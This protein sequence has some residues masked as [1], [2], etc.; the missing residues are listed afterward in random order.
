MKIHNPTE[1]CIVRNVVTL[2]HM[3]ALI[4]TEEEEARVFMISSSSKPLELCLSNKAFSNQYEVTHQ[5]YSFATE[6]P[7][8]KKNI[9]SLKVD[10]KYTISL[11]V[12]D[13]TEM[14]EED[15][16]YDNSETKI[17]SET[18]ADISNVRISYVWISYGNLIMPDENN[19][20]QIS[21]F[22]AAAEFAEALNSALNK[23]QTPKET[24]MKNT[25]I[26]KASSAVATAAQVNKNALNVVA[27]ISAGSTVLQIA[28]NRIE[29][30]VP[31]K[32]LE[33][34]KAYSATPIG[35]YAIANMIAMAQSQFLAGNAKAE[36]IARGAVMA[37][38]QEI[39]AALPI[40]QMIVD[41]FSGVEVNLPE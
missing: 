13:V 5:L 38:M 8:L 6:A 30:I 33:L 34:F 31:E 20:R 15:F 11:D 1:I 7:K 19:H 14:A 4:S 37:G 28:I 23:P 41:L 32:N 29:Q 24:E 35:K 36:Y 27:Q 16:E 40:Q 17:D 22:Q 3:P 18:S 26:E 39:V 2:V 12:S 21:Y 10:D 9:K 25:V